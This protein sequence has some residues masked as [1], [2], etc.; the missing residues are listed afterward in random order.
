MEGLEIQEGVIALGKKLLSSLK[1]DGD[2]DETIEWMINYLAEQIN[3]AEHSDESHRR[4]A[5]ARCFDTI[6]T[7][8]KYRAYFP[9]GTRPF[10]QFDSIFRALSSLDPEGE[11]SRYYSSP[12]G[13]EPKLSDAAKDWI[14]LSKGLD[15]TAKILVSFGFQQAIEETTDADTKEWLAL[16]KKGG[17]ES[18]ELRVLVNFFKDNDIPV[19]SEKERKIEVYTKRIQQLKA[20]N[21]MSAALLIELEVKLGKLKSE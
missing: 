5:R 21:S 17:V 4:E 12:E 14:D 6:L 20:F 8:W 15:N 11:H 7:L 3:E 2:R 10:K 18:G 13:T 9:S 16:L 19:Q 1:I